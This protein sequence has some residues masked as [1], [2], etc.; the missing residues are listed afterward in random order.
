MREP[1]LDLGVPTVH[2]SFPQ[3]LVRR[4]WQIAATFQSE[5]LAP[6]DV[7]SWQ[8]ALLTQIHETPGKDR[9]WLASAIGIDAT[10]AG[11][12]LAAFEARGLVAR[13]TN[14]RD[15]RCN[16]FTL[17]PAGEALRIEVVGLTSGVA[18]RMLSPLTE[19]EGE[20]LLRLLARLVDAH[21]VHARPGA[22]RRAPRRARKAA[23]PLPA[24]VAPEAGDRPS[25]PRSA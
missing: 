10:S 24:G 12:A 19:V 11:Q 14:P 6:H 5:V 20:T 17:T 7:V 1:N 18:R 15:R 16:A 3:H 2:R 25:P 22:G 23:A 9:N 13:A 21:E 4:L 8:V